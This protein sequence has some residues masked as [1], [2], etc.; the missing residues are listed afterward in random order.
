MTDRI[1][2]AYEFMVELGVV[3]V[4]L[5]LTPLAAIFTEREP[6]PADEGEY[7]YPYGEPKF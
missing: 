4:T 6:E 7:L 5:I 1:K 2:D 3:L